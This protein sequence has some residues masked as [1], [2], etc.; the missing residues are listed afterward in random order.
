MARVE[1]IDEPNLIVPLAASLNQRGIAGFTQAITNRTDQ[2]KINTVY[3][4]IT[5]AFTG[6]TTLYVGKRP[7]VVDSGGVYGTSTNVSYFHEI[8]PDGSVPWLFYKHGDDVRA[9]VNGGTSTNITTSAVN[10]IPAFID[11]TSIGGVDEAIVIQ[12]RNNA[13]FAQTV[14]QSAGSNPSAGFTQLTLQGTPLGKME[15]LD[16]YGFI[17]DVDGRIWNSQ[18]NTLSTWPAS[19]WISRTVMQD[20]ATGLARLGNQIISF[21]TASMEVFRNAG[22]AA[23]SPLESVKPLSKNY[24]LPTPNTIGKRHYYAVLGD[25]LY[26]RGSNPTGV[27]AYNGMTVEKVSTPAV[28]KIIGQ[29]DVYFVGVITFSGK[30][31]VVFGL[32]LVTDATQRALLFFP[33][34]KDWILWESSVFIPQTSPRNTEVLLGGPGNTSK[35]FNLSISAENYRDAGTDYTMTLQFKLPTNGNAH[36]RL[37]MFGVKGD[38]AASTT[39]STL[40]VRFTTD[41][42]QTSTAARDIDLTKAKKHIYRCG[43]YSDLGVYLDHTG[44]LNCRLEAALAR[45]E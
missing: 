37:Q 15:F 18:L 12:L 44:N 36:Q 2:L 20:T 32:N 43:G 17:S 5:N 1:Y 25:W 8:A 6:K 24:G 14:W 38:T 29:V 34:W 30:A 28:D 21:G 45:V 16:G 3:E 31:A 39:T 19:A 11:K 4:P 9:A 41:D 35:L 10:V 23:G 40:K 42:W 27:F 26:W 33:S 22:N 7:G 13:S